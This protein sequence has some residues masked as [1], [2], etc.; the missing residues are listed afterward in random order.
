MSREW[1][2]TRGQQVEHT[3][4][5]PCSTALSAAIGRR[6][7]GQCD[8]ANARGPLSLS[9]LASSAR[10]YA[11]TMRPRCSQLKVASQHLLQSTAT[12][13]L[14]SCRRSVVLVP[15][16]SHRA[17]GAPT[18]RLAFCGSDGSPRR[19]SPRRARLIPENSRRRCRRGRSHPDWSHR[20]HH[21]YRKSILPSPL[22][23]DAGWASGPNPIVNR[24]SRIVNPL[25]A[26][27]N[28]MTFYP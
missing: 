11:A 7:T 16:R 25:G 9:R 24:K 19:D 28:A 10:R 13:P 5:F 6:Q 27:A 22:L 23:C 14:K 18:I 1:S 2:F 15:Q 3:A 26:D 21:T 17:A 20:S 12:R 8:A 4:P